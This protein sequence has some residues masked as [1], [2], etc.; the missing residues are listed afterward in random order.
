MGGLLYLLTF[1]T[2][3]KETVVLNMCK[4]KLDCWFSRVERWS[5]GVTGM[6]KLVWVGIFGLPL[7]CWNLTNFSRIGEG[8]GGSL[9]KLSNETEQKLSFAAA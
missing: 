6:M 9:I 2:P 5:A 7:E 3:E 8:W 1:D 4:E